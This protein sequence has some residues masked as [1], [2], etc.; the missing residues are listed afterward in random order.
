MRY[1]R[2]SVVCFSMLALGCDGSRRSLLPTRP[3]E[4]P[5][6][7]TTP[8][9]PQAPRVLTV[10]ATTVA[11]GEVVNSRVTPD[12]PLC[13]PGWPH[14]CRYYR[15]TIAEDGVLDV[16]MGWSPQ[17]PDP[18]PLDIDVLGSFGP[19][20]PTQVGPGP[21]RRVGVR[22]KAGDTCLIE[23]WSFLTPGEEF[24]LTTSLQAE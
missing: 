13:D 15:L 16:A 3:S 21:R 8:T 20:S 4:L 2:F 18:Y 9:S 19:V 22:V 6:T 1:V 5:P 23:I 11:V 7:A 14:R 12:D 10:A 17:Q 24:E